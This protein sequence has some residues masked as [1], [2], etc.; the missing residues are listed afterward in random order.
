MEDVKAATTA[1][2]KMPGEWIIRKG[3]YSNA[4]F[5]SWNIDP[6]PTRFRDTH[7]DLTIAAIVVTAELA[8][9][10]TFEYALVEASAFQLP[11]ATKAHGRA[12]G[13]ANSWA[14]AASSPKIPC[15]SR[16]DVPG[17]ARLPFGV[18]PGRGIFPRAL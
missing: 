5:H 6:I 14:W 16:G 1:I 17:L 10:R 7:V 11:A 13:R 12:S 8:T 4:S 15:F 9:R 3:V 2:E 18:G